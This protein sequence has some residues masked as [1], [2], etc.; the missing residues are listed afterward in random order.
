MALSCRSGLK[1]RTAD[2]SG[3][4]A[5]LE[6]LMTSTNA[7]QNIEGQLNRCLRFFPAWGI[8]QLL[9]LIL[10][11][12]VT[13]SPAAAQQQT[14]FLPLAI[15][16][17]EA[18]RLATLA[19]EALTTAVS[20]SGEQ[21][22]SRH[23]AEKQFDYGVAWPPAPAAVRAFAAGQAI[24]YVALGSLTQVD[25]G[26]S[27]DLAAYD[28]LSDAPPK[29]FYGRAESAAELDRVLSSLVGE[30]LTHT[31][32]HFLIGEIGVEGNRRIDSGAILR[33][34]RTQAGDRYQPD[35]LRED[36]KNVFQM[37]Y[38]DDVRIDAVDT[39]RGK[40]VTF[41]VDEKPVLNRVQITGQDR[42]KDED[43]R[44]VITL[45]V[46]NIIRSKEVEDSVENIRRLYREKGFYNT[47]V[48][49]NLNYPKPDR[50]DVDF[51]IEEGEKVLIRDINFV[52]NDSFS[53]RQLKKVIST[54]EKGFF[55]WFTDSGVLKR[56]EVEQD[57]ARITAFYNNHGFIDAAVG[58]PEI[59]QKEDRLYVTFHIA[60][61]ERYEVGQVSLSGDLVES[62]GT[63]LALVRLK[64]EKYFS[65]RILRED[66]LRL[67]D[68]YADR[69]YAFADAAPLLDRNPQQKTVAVT[70]DL[71]Q[72]NIVHINRIIIEGNTRTRDRVIRRDMEVEE[73][74]IFSA[75]GLRA[76]NENLQRLGFFDKVNIT[77]EP[78][79]AEDLMDILVQVEERPT[80]TFSVGAGYSS[81]DKLLFMTEISQNNFLGKGQRLSLQANISGNATRYNFSFTEPRVNDSQLLFG[82]D[83]YDW[84]REYDEYT[85]DSYGFALRFGYPV[86][87]RWRMF[88]SYGYDRTDLRD[89][90]PLAS[91]VIL[92]SRDINVTSAARIGFDRDTRNRRYDPSRGSLYS[93]NLKYAGGPLGGD[94]EFTKLEG[95]SS[96]YFPFKWATNFHLRVAG[97]LVTENKTGQLPVFERFY[98]GG[99]STVRG[100]DFGEISP[101]ENG[102]KIGG[103]KMWYTNLEYIFPIIKDAGLKGVIFVDAGDSID[104]NLPR[105]E[106]DRVRYSAGAGFRWLSPMGPLRLEWGYNLDPK[107]DEEQSS[108]DFSI[109]GTF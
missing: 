23:E 93:I 13:A 50:V 48:T 35:L 84:R 69:G 54:S 87:E 78:T 57:A 71:Q 103:R 96:W 31:G 25:A 26:F 17:P 45:R 24:D 39:E 81:V 99:L 91:S 22:L 15:H 73:S 7:Q 72:N 51:V 109:G 64:D 34:V 86:W 75:S 6:K 60:E 47:R 14:L 66:I 92:R 21:V 41:I 59:T 36:L 104:R 4:R 16:A 67:T 42:I 8:Y 70:I 100:F 74:G 53:E 108:W 20:A 58:K 37:G 61:G 77:P 27:I 12:Q 9:L 46:N 49:A 62:E 65:R 76:S 97:G 55:S 85:R 43:I 11:L 83:L 106:F 33:N 90:D 82:L 32:R 98:L 94:A 19:D 44:Q 63:L 10:V 5:I 30:I 95:S 52:G 105:T 1:T 3:K 88:W 56:D 107:G 40:K 29:Y 102:D 38:F 101:R 80:G 89:V 79:A 28:L 2:P 18:G 68:F